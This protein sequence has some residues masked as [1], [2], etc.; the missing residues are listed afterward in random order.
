M[1]LCIHCLFLYELCVQIMF[2]CET[3]CTNTAYGIFRIK[4]SVRCIFLYEAIGLHVICTNLCMQ[5]MFLYDACV[6]TVYFSTKRF[7][8]CVFQYE[9]V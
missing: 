3:V 9:T 2:L 1:K 7:V 6:R 5:F 8:K 4:L